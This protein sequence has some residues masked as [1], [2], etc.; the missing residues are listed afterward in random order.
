MRDGSCPRCHGAEIYAARNALDSDLALRA[1]IEPG[2]R[3][4]RPQVR[5]EPWT[6]VCAACGLLETYVLDPEPLAFVRQAWLRVP[7]PPPPPTP[8]GT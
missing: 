5:V 1:H 6:Y 3:G 7:P 4:M 2:F 8:S